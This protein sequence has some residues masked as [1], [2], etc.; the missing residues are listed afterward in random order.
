MSL[1][2]VFYLGIRPFSP[3]KHGIKGIILHTIFVVALA[4]LPLVVVI[5]VAD[6]MIQGITNR[7]IETSSYHYRVFSR[8]PAEV[9]DFE[10]YRDTVEELKNNNQIKTATIERTGA[11][12]GVFKE[13]KS[14][15]YIRSVE[16]GIM[17]SDVGM[18]QFMEVESGEFK[19]D[20]NS[21]VISS[22]LASKSGISI[23]QEF[24]VVTG[25]ILQ[26]GKI[27][28]KVTSY[29]VSGII[30][31][32]YEELDRLW[33]FI[34]L[35]QGVKILPNRSSYTF[36]GIKVDDAYSENSEI[37]RNIK[38]V[39]PS[40]W[41]IREWSQLNRNTYENF[42]TTKMVLSLIMGLIVI[43]AAINISSSLIMLV[44]EKRRD[45]AILKSMG[46]SPGDVM[47]AF[48][49]TGVLIGIIGTVIGV[50]FGIL[51]SLN[52]NE[53]I[54]FFEQLINYVLRFINFI[55]NISSDKSFILLESEYYLDDIPVD[56][57]L[58]KLILMTIFSISTT[59]I[60]SFFP[61]KK[62]GLIKPLK[63][64]QKY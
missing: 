59:A 17:K 43:V 26:N 12:V 20:D 47:G 22:Y 36:I 35:D 62:A 7:Y 42:K 5:V 33:V 54:L 2:T 39:M 46:L 1:K 4:M 21:I 8:Q 64:M 57:D 29:K 30:K 31:T 25:K 63:I 19:L 50:I 34:S 49:L 9:I 45:I 11:G 55:F 14:G 48:L 52:I 58:S 44:L 56:L 13:F 40:G 15:I 27:L 18:K 61:A 28:P 23:G 24:S 32:G 6:G 3:K 51:I 10:T 41:I 38:K 16:P 60:A 53:L 37:Y